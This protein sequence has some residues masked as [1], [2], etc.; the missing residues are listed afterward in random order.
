MP[1]ASPTGPFTFGRGNTAS[2]AFMALVDEACAAASGIIAALV[3]ACTR[4]LYDRELK[5]R[6]VYERDALILSGKLLKAQEAQMRAGFGGCLREAILNPP[7]ERKR[8]P[9]A[10]DVLSLDQL[11]LMDED[12][13]QESVSLARAQQCAMLE[14]DVQLNELNTLV[15]SALGL[16]SVRTESN[17]LR[18]QVFITALK[19]LLDR[20]A[21]PPAAR[22]DWFAT[23]SEAL[24]P[25]LR[26]YY[27]QSAQQLRSQGVVAAGYV[28]LSSPGAPP[29]AARAVVQGDA[30]AG[31]GP[32]LPSLPSAPLPAAA[33]ATWDWG[34]GHP[35]DA[36][37]VGS[38][39][40]PLPMAVQPLPT[41]AA[42]PVPRVV[43]RSA[44]APAPHHD[45]ALLNLDT[46][47][48]LLAGELDNSPAASVSQGEAFARRLSR[49][50]EA[51]ESLPALPGSDFISTVPAAFEA[52]SEMRQVERV[53]QKLQQRQGAGASGALGSGQDATGDSI[54]AVRE[55]MRRHAKGMAQALSLEVVQL[56]V[57]NLARDP[58]LLGPV[59][60]LVRSLE[61]ALLRLSLVDPRFFSDK[62]HPARE[63]LLQITQRSLAFP[64]VDTPGFDAFLAEVHRHVDLLG[65]LYIGDA[66]P[67]QQVLEALQAHWEQAQATREQEQAQV[68]AILQH[69]EARNLLAQRIARKVEAHPD[70]ARVPA[71][72]V[73]FLCG[74]WAQVVAHARLTQGAGSNAASK[75]EAL[76]AALL[77]SV[78]PELTRNKVSKLTRLV[79][80]LLS[81][82]RSGLDTIQYPATKTSA[83]LEA[84]MGLHQRMFRQASGKPADARE[85]QALEAAQ[86]LQGGARSPRRG[87]DDG[88]PW[89]GP[90]EAQA[91][92][93][94]ECPDLPTVQPEAGLAQEDLLPGMVLPQDV[95]SVLVQ[96]PQV[97]DGL[98]LGSWIELLQDSQWVRTQLTWA[99]PHGTLFLFTNGQGKTQSM[100]R[101]SRDKLV[102]A[103]QMRLVSAKAVVEGALN[104]VAQ[105]AARNSIGEDRG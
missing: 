37:D 89:I 63:L 24:G 34:S 71:V 70:A 27:A 49:Q 69:A 61:P 60:T 80:M 31:G 50:F 84:L 10:L 59:Q 67:F 65:R 77:W 97:L 53:V 54:E 33:S 2:P 104:A 73:D 85:T 3:G 40:D 96:D 88:D 44:S 95:D 48:R 21:V 8:A 105:A 101:R 28:V 30:S 42:P 6:T 1:S 93:F 12:Q 83:F 17:P 57:D 41:D 72:V 16:G 68:V 26:N 20:L 7:A 74:P 51:G 38:V 81:T 52:L 39:Q 86:A 22:Q 32:P 79:P 14:A 92:N 15:S 13:V 18:P 66:G 82:L 75:Y 25:E 4:S 94:M 102:A 55:V 35:S 23:M 91:S 87:V 58:R 29:P 78:H 99:S 36:L 103:G 100:T 46:L 19:T 56:M 47:R 98:A 76:I 45:P 90:Q 64:R 5:A 11:E 43:A 9:Q 62:Q